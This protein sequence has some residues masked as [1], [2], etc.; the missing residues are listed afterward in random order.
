M[1]RKLGIRRKSRWS[2]LHSTAIKHS[3]IMLDLVRWL[4]DSTIWSPPNIS[5]RICYAL[6]IEP[7]Y[8]AVA[9]ERMK[10][11]GLKPKLAA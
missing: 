2:N 5:K 9:L 11:M 7:K 8:V 3:R 4:R 10:D 1:M 6:E